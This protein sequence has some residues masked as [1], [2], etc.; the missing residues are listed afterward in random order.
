[1]DD[2]KFKLK[3]T[4]KFLAKISNSVPANARQQY[5][6]EEN[7]QSFLFFAS[8]VIEIVKRRINDEFGIFDKDNVFYIHGLR[9]NLVDSGAQKM[10]KD[11]ISDYFT[12]PKQLKPKINLSKSSLWKMQSLR[13]QA[14]H[15]NIIKYHGKS[16]TFSYT[17]HQGQNTYCFAQ[18]TQNPQRYFGQ[19]SKNLEKFTN[20][21]DYILK[22]T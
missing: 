14:M 3:T 10:A 15:G 11:A 16:L 1:M 22:S 2:L 20:Q 8:G 21:I 6:M 4:R 12:T 7:V 13:N 17:I 5:S 18:K 9:K 19:M